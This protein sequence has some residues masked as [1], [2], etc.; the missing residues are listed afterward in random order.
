MIKW[1]G[2][3]HSEFCRHGSGER[4]AEMVERA[5][6]LGFKRYSIT[7]HAPLPPGVM[8]E[9]ELAA[10]FT[11]LPDELDEYFKHLS[12]IKKKYTGKIDV[13]AGLEIDYIAGYEHHINSFIEKC[14]PY[15]DDLLVSV[16]MIEGKSGMAPIDFTPE[17][18]AEELVDYYGSIEQVHQAYWSVVEAM[19]DHR[20][21]TKL[22]KRIG[23]L[24]LINKFIKKFPLEHDSR[25]YETF[26]DD[27]FK[28]IKLNGWHLDYNVAGLNKEL[29]QDLYISEEMLNYCRKYG[30]QLV[31]GSDAHDVK[32]VG[33]FYEIYQSKIST[34]NQD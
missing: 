28:K 29:F 33:Q 26:L 7:E 15:L 6:E 21:N 22:S 1:D 9:P 13:L 12:E 20:F 31:Y 5:I 25:F 32:S 2:H 3:T 18:F 27:L 34:L 17:V 11:L 8:D 30:V 24:G 10:E 14:K 19:I 16:H 23:H 4:T